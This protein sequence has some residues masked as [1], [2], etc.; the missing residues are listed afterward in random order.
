MSWSFSIG[1]TPLSDLKPS[2]QTLQLS[3]QHTAEEKAQL[4]K[5][6]KLALELATSG[7][8]GDPH[9]VYVSLTGHA[10]AGHEDV[11]G[12]ANSSVTIS[13]TH[14]TVSLEPAEVEDTGEGI[15]DTDVEQ[16]EQA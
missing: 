9:S 7:T 12:E 8:V 5:A 14:A 1:P 11:E 15:I 3:D 4:A 13:V 16:A 6:T 10:L 2:L